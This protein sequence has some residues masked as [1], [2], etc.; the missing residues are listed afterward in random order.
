MSKNTYQ[1]L[2]NYQELENEVVSLEYELSRYKR[3][4]ER[5]MSGDL[6]KVKLHSD[7][8]GAKVEEFIADLEWDL[9]HKINE[10]FEAEKMIKKLKGLNHQILYQKHIKGKTL[11]EIADELGKSPNYIYNKHAELMRM[12]KFKYDI[13]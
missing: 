6:F 9:A 7:S 10:L 12:L 2:L 8:K 5:W 11:I 4:L 3:E 1:W 13:I